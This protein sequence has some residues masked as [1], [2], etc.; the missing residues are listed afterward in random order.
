M[1]VSF[2]VCEREQVDVILGWSGKAT[3]VTLPWAVAIPSYLLVVLL[4]NCRSKNA[5]R[6]AI[7]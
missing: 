4:C 2:L 1:F 5:S 3:S 7:M 6:K